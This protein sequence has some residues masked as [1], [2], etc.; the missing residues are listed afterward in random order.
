MLRKHAEQLIKYLNMA[1]EAIF[2]SVDDCP[3]D[4]RKAFADIHEAT[5]KVGLLLARLDLLPF[6]PL[7]LYRT[8]HWWRPVQTALTPPSRASCSFAFSHRLC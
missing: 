2:E 7:V 3:G 6:Q 8:L 4:M 1:L 5:G